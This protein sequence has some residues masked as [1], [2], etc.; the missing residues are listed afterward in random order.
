MLSCKNDRVRELRLHTCAMKASYQYGHSG[1]MMAMRSGATAHKPEEIST[2][3]KTGIRFTK[4]P[5]ERLS[6]APTIREGRMRSDA[7]SADLP[8]TS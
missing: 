7:P 2:T 1:R 4:M 8:W 5:V 6:R 3:H